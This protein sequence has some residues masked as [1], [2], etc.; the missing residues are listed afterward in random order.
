M[1][2]SLYIAVSREDW[3]TSIFIIPHNRRLL[4]WIGKGYFTVSNIKITPFTTVC[5]N[6]K[7]GC[8]I[9]IRDE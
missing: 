6:I 5:V 8:P 2:G 9:V 7:P 4:S 3:W 1:I